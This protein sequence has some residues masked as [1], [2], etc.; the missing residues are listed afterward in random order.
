VNEDGNSN[1]HGPPTPLR[2]AGANV[3][4]AIFLIAILVAVV[5]ALLAGVRWHEPIA[6]ELGLGAHQFSV[7]A[8]SGD[9]QFW[10]CS[11]HPQVIKEEPGLCPICHMQLTP[12]NGTTADGHGTTAPS[13]ER[14]VKY[15]WDPMLGADSITDRPGKSAMGMDLVPVYDDQISGGAAVTIDPVIVQNMGV[16]VAPVGRGPVRRTIRAV[17]YVAEAQPMIHDVNLRVSG[18][19]EKLYANVEGMH[20][21]QGDPLFDLYSPEMQVA[22]EELIGAG[23][24]DAGLGPQADPTARK[25]SETL[26]AAARRKLEQWGLDAKQV[27]EL[28]KQQHAPRT[29]AFLSPATGHVTQ[30]N[31]VEGTN[32]KAGDRALQIVDHSALWLDVQVYERDLPFV[33]MGQPVTATVDAVPGETFTGKVVFI[34]PHLDP[35]TRTA[36]VRAELPNPEIKLRPGMYATARITAELSANALLVPR[37]AVIDT[38]TRQVAFV[39][40]E[41]GRFEPRQ[42]KLGVESE[43]GMVQV[44]EGLGPGEP[45]VISG[46]FLLDAESRMRE[47][48]QKHLD[49][50]LLAGR[51]ASPAVQAQRPTAATTPTMPMTAPSTMR[52]STERSTTPRPSSP[53]DGVVSA[54]IEVQ[55]ALGAV[56]QADTPVETMR[57]ADAARKLK[58]DGGDIADAAAH[59]DTAASEMGG[60]PIAEQRKLFKPLSDAVIALAKR[61]PP[62]SNVA[63]KLFIAHCPMAF[64]KGADWL[65]TSETIANPYFPKAMKECGSIAGTIETRAPASPDPSAPSTQRGDQR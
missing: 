1:H 51:P 38:G 53:S 40:G 34:H 43:G 62:S 55:E 30:K 46:Q 16:R 26:T 59:V 8:A 48:I 20:V 11:M 33:A 24:A 25:A 56:Q 64:G 27:D 13:A 10:T 50:K 22:V 47:A 52:A 19:V 37:E 32:V 31:V 2:S 44:L 29:V 45:V 28:A 14:K 60:K 54:Y 61:S 3:R 7:A 58:R 9:K 21:N 5:A 4:G 23:R 57:I 42:L 36:T 63:A 15:W 49:E 18:W 6:Q 41:R 17:G 12:L 35:T 39:A 65:Q